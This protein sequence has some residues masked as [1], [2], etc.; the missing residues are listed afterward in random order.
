MVR[1][2]KAECC[3]NDSLIHVMTELMFLTCVTVSAHP[4]QVQSVTIGQKHSST[5]RHL[6]KVSQH[7]TINEHLHLQHCLVKYWTFKLPMITDL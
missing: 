1:R 7:N 3:I 4:G 6:N 5:L 2:Q